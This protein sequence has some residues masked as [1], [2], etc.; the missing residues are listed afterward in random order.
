[1]IISLAPLQGLTN[2]YYRKVYSNHF[3]GIDKV[4][5]PYIR[6]SEGLTLKT[7][8]LRDFLPENNQCL[9]AIPQIMTKHADEF[10]FMVN[11]FYDLGYK[12]VNWNLGCPFPMVTSHQLG[13]GLLAHPAKVEE[14]LAIGMPQIKARI[15]IKMRI[16]FVDDQDIFKL[17]PIFEKFPLSEIIIHP[18][19]GKQQY[20]GVVN[21]V[22][23]EECL[24]NTSHLITYNGDIESLESFNALSARFAS[25]H[26]W[27]IGRGVL[28]NPFLPNE[29]KT[30][31]RL[32]SLDKLAIFTSFHNALYEELRFAIEDKNHFL[33]RLRGFWEYFSLSFS[34]SHKV[35]K[36]I[37]K[38][39]SISD[40]N[41]ALTK[42]LNSEEW[43]EIS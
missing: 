10:V 12:E 32:S 30:G 22:V 1:M 16:G 7:T 4:Y 43:V 27:M 20:K 35:F 8:K 34:N 39:N 37:K 5:M 38:A 11:Y 31:I 40:Y 28:A 18:R 19:T 26:S 6:A 15:S 29:I 21:L 42:I 36:C 13:A 14:I 9:P 33:I 2:S 23:F 25:I 17:L 24:K 3:E 41:L